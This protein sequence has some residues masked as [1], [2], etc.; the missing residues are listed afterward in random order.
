VEAVRGLT[1]AV[2]AVALSMGPGRAEEPG[3]AGRM[4]DEQIEALARKAMASTDEHLQRSVLAQLEAHHFKS[5]LARER[6]TVL[7]AQGLLQDRPGGLHELPEP[8][9]VGRGDRHRVCDGD[10]IMRDPPHV[11]D[12]V[13][14]GGLHLRD[15]V[16]GRLA[17]VDS[18]SGS[19][20]NAAVPEQDRQDQYLTLHPSRIVSIE[21]HPVP[22]LI[23][24][25][26]YVLRRSRL[27]DLLPGLVGNGFVV[28]FGDIEVE[29]FHLV[30]GR[31]D[32]MDQSILQSGPAHRLVGQDG[33]QI[34]G[35]VR[36]VTGLCQFLQVHG[37]GLGSDLHLAFLDE[38]EQDHRGDAPAQ[39]GEVLL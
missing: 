21:H 39:S 36:V 23:K 29:P 8:I 24:H 15:V 34:L 31:F 12:Q 38:G 18:R 13:G 25:P 30:P 4:T 5:S 1:A 32:E 16:R 28:V 19:T 2:L 9:P 20:G 7:F 14:G 17:H 22:L 3:H 6:E 27:L 11:I 26:G 10:H 33:L 37:G 35:L